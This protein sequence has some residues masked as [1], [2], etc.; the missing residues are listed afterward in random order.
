MLLAGCSAKSFRSLAER[1]ADCGADS[2]MHR[3]LPRGFLATAVCL[4]VGCSGSAPSAPASAA[5]V[6]GTPVELGADWPAYHRDAGRSGVSTDM[7]TP[8]G[9]AIVAQPV[10]DGQVY[11]SPLVVGK[12][13]IVATEGDSVY[14]LDETGGQNWRTQ[15]GD[16]SP[17]GE[18]ACGNIDPLGITGTPVHASGLI[19]VSPQYRGGR[20]ELVA[21]DANSGTV[22]WRTGLDLPGVD[23][24][25]MQQRGALTVAGGRVWVPFGGLAGDCGN[26]KGRLIGVPL[27]GG[28][29]VQF[30]VPT[31]RE[32]GIWTPPGPSV[33]VNGL[34]YVSVGNGESG[35]GDKYDFSDSVLKLDQTGRLVDSFS[36]GTWPADNDADLDLGS[37]GPALVGTKWVVIAGKSGSAYVLRQ[38]AL[39][40]IGGQVWT[41]PVCTSYGGSAVQADVVYLPC[42]DGVRAARVAADGTLTV[43][44]RAEGAIAGSPVIGGGRIW[45]LAPENGTLHALDPATGRSTMDIGVGDVTRFATPALSGSLV[46]VPTKTGITIVRTDQAASS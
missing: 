25:A 31:S 45:A 7:R 38:S 40:G 9:L 2:G 33:D 39:G 14:S 41:G 35:V 16:P 43:R 11:A 34:L 30:T 12:R 5:A 37:Q 32:A 22:R 18:R 1:L 21:L 20:H 44:W 46:I 15:L 4:L 28:K 23:P 10:L 27:G 3:Y 24:L 42:S 13:I 29:P 36:P 6:T 8:Q 17:A 26:Y 19:Y